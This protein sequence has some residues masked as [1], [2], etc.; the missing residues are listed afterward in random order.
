LALGSPT[1]TSPITQ[2][3][4]IRIRNANTC[5]VSAVIQMLMCMPEIFPDAY[6]G[7]EGLRVLVERID[8]RYVLEKLTGKPKPTLKI[9]EA[10]IFD[11]IQLIDPDMIQT[12]EKGGKEI[13]QSDCSELLV[14]FLEKSKLRT[15][16]ITFDIT[17]DVSHL[18]GPGNGTVITQVL[19]AKDP[20]PKALKLNRE[21]VM[22]SSQL[23]SDNMP[24]ICFFPSTMTKEKHKETQVQII[25]RT[26]ESDET[27]VED[28]PKIDYKHNGSQYKYAY[29]C[30][31]QAITNVE[32]AT[33]RRTVT[34]YSNFGQ[35]VIV[36]NVVMNRDQKRDDLTID[37][38]DE[39]V[40]LGGSEYDMKC[41]IVHNGESMTGGH[42][43]C[44]SKIEGAWYGTSDSAVH[45]NTYES[46]DDFMKKQEALGVSAAL[47]AIVLLERR[48]DA[49]VAVTVA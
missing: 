14:K 42:Y 25:H 24:L 40:I 20:R 27:I 19:D 38:K 18:C 23:A 1:T 44:V 29:K 41:V 46:P 30:G 32:K 34:T 31:D 49:T 9:S 43:V 16:K 12:N 17:T 6:V 3:F 26:I 5:F 45:D 39:V 33:N 37:L 35:Y 8:P 22:R 36:H 4:G 47:P 7:D 15:D 28:L 2:A 48:R 21:I 10:V 11:A 13:I